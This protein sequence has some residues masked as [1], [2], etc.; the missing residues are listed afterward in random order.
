VDQVIN[1]IQVELVY[2]EIL[3]S[4]IKLAAMVTKSFQFIQHVIELIQMENP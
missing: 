4:I 3:V 1:N 2:V